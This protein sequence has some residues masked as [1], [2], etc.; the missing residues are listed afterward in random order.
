MACTD[1]VKLGT[2]T[3]GTAGCGKA[4]RKLVDFRFGC[5]DALV[6]TISASVAPVCDDGY[7]SDIVSLDPVG[8]PTPLYYVDVIEA[9][10]LDELDDFTFDRTTDVGEDTYSINPTIK[11]YNPD[12]QCV[13]ESLKGE[14]IVL[15]YKIENQSGDYIWRRFFGIV[16]AVTGGLLAGYQLTIDVLNPSSTDKPMYINTGT[17]DLTTADLDA[18]TNF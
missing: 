18:L 16:T 5:A 7:I 4:A 17:A 14:E 8:D 2:I 3:K 13:F 1:C 9:D 6:E 11:I 10:D 15:I 12:H